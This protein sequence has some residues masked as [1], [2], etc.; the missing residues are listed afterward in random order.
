MRTL[1]S[2]QK[3]QVGLRLPTYL[4][5]EL[6]ALG[7]SY[8]LNRSEIITEAINSYIQEQKA[9]IFYKEFDEAAKELKAVLSGDKK[10]GTLNELIDELSDN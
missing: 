4:V 3:Q 9:L 5:E 2:L 6:D 1:A 10:A 7:A 8:E